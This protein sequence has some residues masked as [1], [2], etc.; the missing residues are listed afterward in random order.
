MTTVSLTSEHPIK[1]TVHS[2]PC[3]IR[4]TGKAKVSDYFIETEPDAVIPNQCGMNGSIIGNELDQSKYSYKK[5]YCYFRG[6][7]LLKN[8]VKFDK[9]IKG[10]RLQHTQTANNTESVWETTGVFEE[11]NVWSLTNKT[12]DKYEKSVNNWFKI[13]QA[14]HD[15]VET[16]TEPTQNEQ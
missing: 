6:R 1:V 12:R 13:S 9:A 8:T 5:P 10:Y 11:V 4:Y 14:L 15:P 2:L 3:K 16:P 7:A